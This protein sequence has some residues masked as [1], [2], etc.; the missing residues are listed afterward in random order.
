MLEHSGS[1]WRDTDA[2]PAEAG[3]DEPAF[4]ILIVDDDLTTLAILRLVASR[5]GNCE[6]DIESSPAA[7]LAR[8]RSDP[9][10]LLVLDH[11]MPEMTGLTLVNSL[12]SDPRTAD[13]ACIAITGL[14][15]D[16]LAGLLRERGVSRVFF[17]PIDIA[18]FRQ[19]IVLL[20][21]GLRT[22]QSRSP[23]AYG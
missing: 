14:H 20:R 7:A 8:C 6:C 5:I 9:P 18:A 22:R 13:I 19:E 16:V 10:D 3:E 1:E 21:A 23:V 11:V 17:K 4:R 2:R 12:R 15:D